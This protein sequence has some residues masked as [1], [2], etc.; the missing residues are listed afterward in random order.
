MK[1]KNISFDLFRYQ[2]LPRSR[3]LQWDLFSG[4]KSLDDLLARKNDIFFRALGKVQIFKTRRTIIRHKILFQD[5]DQILYRFAANRAL[6]RETR[7]F[8]EEEIEN[9]PSFFVYIWNNPLKQFIAIQRRW[10]AFQKTEVV[11]KSIADAVNE[12]LGMLN[13]RVLAE[14][15]FLESEFWALIDQHAG[16]IRDI[17]FELI[18]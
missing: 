9:W 16:R 3:T 8:T 13:L 6:K 4:I 2:I 15:L 10:S 7:E 1:A 11:V 18:T 14:A 5:K 12:V 17:R